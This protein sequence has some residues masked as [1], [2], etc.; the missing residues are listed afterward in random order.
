VL[1]GEHRWLEKGLVPEMLEKA[2][3]KREEE[4]ASA[5]R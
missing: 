2:V 3:A 1:A 4:A 5:R